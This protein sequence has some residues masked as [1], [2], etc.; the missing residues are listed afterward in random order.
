[1]C[2]IFF[3]FE[4]VKSV[5]LHGVSLQPI[6]LHLQDNI[7]RLISKYYVWVS[8]YFAELYMFVSIFRTDKILGRD[9]FMNCS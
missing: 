7:K 6:H 5:H 4:M 3:G 1:M 8:I 9:L 2:A